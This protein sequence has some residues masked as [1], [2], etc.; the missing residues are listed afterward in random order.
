M[1]FKYQ[2]NAAMDRLRRL[3]ADLFCSTT[4]KALPLNGLHPSERMRIYKAKQKRDIK[5]A[6][7][8]AQ[9][10]IDSN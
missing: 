3:C 4:R 9:Y 6:K 2:W 10:F 7:R 1:P 5:A 8:R